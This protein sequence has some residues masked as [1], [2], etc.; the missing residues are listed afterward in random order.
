[1]SKL[2]RYSSIIF[3]CDGVILNS[4]KIKTESFHKV[5]SQFSTS[6]ADELAE[7]HTRNGGIS[8]YKKFEYLL[9]DI[10]NSTFSS[11][12][13]DALSQQYGALVFSQLLI[14]EASAC[15]QELSKKQTQQSWMVVSGGA[16]VELREVFSQRKISSLFESG[17]FGSP[18]DK[19]KILRREID[20]GNLKFPAVFLGDSKYDHEAATR[21]GLDFIFISGWS[22]F[23]GWENYVREKNIRSVS[24]LCDLM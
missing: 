7:Y 22:E 12:D 19:D 17:I 9:S 10:L 4:N 24:S 5:A 23:S 3:D 1:M 21:A 15:L 16:Q 8:R 11:A 14:C 13:V 18:D 2:D 20:C 6:A